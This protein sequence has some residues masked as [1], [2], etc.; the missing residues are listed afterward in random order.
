MLKGLFRNRRGS[1]EPSLIVGAVVVIVLGV[2]LLPVI[3]SM[4]NATELGVN[5]TTIG[6]LVDLLPLLY[7]VVLIV[8]TIGYVVVSTRGF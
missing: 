3:T 1:I 4:A 7:V 2:S 6:T 5:G 8:G